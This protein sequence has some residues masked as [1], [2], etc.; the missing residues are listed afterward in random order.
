MFQAN[1][2]QKKAEMALLASVMV[3]FRSKNITRDKRGSLP[4]DK[5]VSSL[6]RHRNPKC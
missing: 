1:I 3:D 2:N 5:G 6:G 4:N